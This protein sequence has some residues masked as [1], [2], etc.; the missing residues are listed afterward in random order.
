MGNGVCMGWWWWWVGV[1]AC[2]HQECV[3]QHE[4]QNTRRPIELRRGGGALLVSGT[5]VGGIGVGWHMPLTHP[6]KACW[7]ARQSCQRTAAPP[8]S[9]ARPSGAG[10]C[11]AAA[12]QAASASKHAEEGQGRAE[13]VRGCRWVGEGGTHKGKHGHMLSRQHPPLIIPS[14]FEIRISECSCEA[15][16]VGQITCSREHPTQAWCASPPDPAW[17]GYLPRRRPP[18]SWPP[19]WR[20]ACPPSHG[21]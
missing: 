18:T 19:V 21:G 17:S 1:C 12:A 10:R 11:R 4:T 6:Q 7:G 16:A 15:N 2:L 5:W 13:G 14:C 8:G 3:S 9:T 20:R